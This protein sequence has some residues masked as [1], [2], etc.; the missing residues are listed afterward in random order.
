MSDEAADVLIVGAG[1]S[2]AVAA[3]RLA[4]AG[5]RVVCLEQGGRS[6]PEDYRGKEHDW[7]LTSLKQWHAN[8]IPVS[9]WVARSGQINCWNSRRSRRYPCR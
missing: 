8:P 1:L 2:G 7:E 4:E 6:S 9:I 5:M 3:R